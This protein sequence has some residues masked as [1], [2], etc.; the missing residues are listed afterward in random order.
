MRVDG[1]TYSFLGNVSSDLVNG[2]VNSTAVTFGPANT[3]LGGQAGPMK[4]NLVFSNPIEVRSH[5]SVTSI[6]TYATYKARRLGKAIHPI[7]VHVFLRKF[8]GQ[9]KSCRAG[10]FRC[11]R[12][13]VRSSFEGRRS[14]SVSLQTGARGIERRKFCGP[15]RPIPM[16]SSI[17]SRSRLQKHS[18]RYLT[19]LNGVRYIML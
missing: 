7:L 13:Y 19:K 12:W 10:V 2:T 4:V 17:V 3:F 9:Q 14:S 5:S 8:V 11:Q 15:R 1:L 18:W 16:S 6:S